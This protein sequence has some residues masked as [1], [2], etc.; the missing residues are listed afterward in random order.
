MVYS[1]LVIPLLGNHKAS[2]K[3]RVIFSNMMRSRTK[4]GYKK[5]GLK[6]Q[7]NQSLKLTNQLLSKTQPPGLGGG[8]VELPGGRDQV[9]ISDWAPPGGRGF[10]RL[11]RSELVGLQE[12]QP[13]KMTKVP[14]SG[15]RRRLRAAEAGDPRVPDSGCASGLVEA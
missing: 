3:C 11:D 2:Q 12:S 15:S 14:R 10:C 4:L 7:S 5:P 1:T 9:A 8:E 6:S 13:I